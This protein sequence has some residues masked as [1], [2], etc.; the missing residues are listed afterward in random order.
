M[1]TLTNALTD[2]VC[3]TA[4]HLRGT[5]GASH[6]RHTRPQTRGAGPGERRPAHAESLESTRGAHAPREQTRGDRMADGHGES[7]AVV[8]LLLLATL[9]L[10]PVL[11]VVLPSVRER[12]KGLS[13]GTATWWGMARAT[14]PLHS[15]AICC[16]VRRC[17]G[18]PC[19]VSTWARRFQWQPRATVGRPLWCRCVARRRGDVLFVV[20]ACT[21][22]DT[23]RSAPS[24]PAA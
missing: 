9:V 24:P 16:V 4:N 13:W 20:L 1:P 19:W 11:A 5:A 23:V 8:L 14:D 15:T 17:S 10:A 7:K 3:G 21:Q 2:P 18:R 22:D 12:L 6:T